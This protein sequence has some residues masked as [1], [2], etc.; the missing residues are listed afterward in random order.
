MSDYT[1]ILRVVPELFET[2]RYRARIMERIA[3]LQPIGRRGLAADMQVTERVLRAELDFLRSQ[4]F[5]HSTAG[6]VFL[7]QEGV[8]VMSELEPVL[9]AVEGRQALALQVSRRLGIE[10]VVVVSGDSDCDSWVKDSLGFRAAEWIQ[11]LLVAG[12]VL[13]VSGGSTLATVAARMPVATPRIPVQVVPARGGL[14]EGLA[15]QANTVAAHVA[16]KL[17]GTSVMFHVPDRLT[18]E[19][20]T[21][22]LADPFV[23]ERLRLIQSATIVVHGIGEARTMAERRQTATPDLAIL[24]E[25]GAVGEAFGYYFDDEGRIA[26]KIAN[27]GLHLAD[28]QTMRCVIAVA[29]GRKKSQAIAAAARGYRIDVLITDEGAAR[30][31]LGRTSSKEMDGR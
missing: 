7:T 20:Q 14:G 13:A 19:S 9:A 3:I 4:G 24:A 25:T 31:I 30:S 1:A 22:L 23:Q 26:H 21:Q 6:G 11:K 18:E 8:R 27:V 10:N 29:G 16:E 15:T 2:L 12:D 28:V 5:V 17:G